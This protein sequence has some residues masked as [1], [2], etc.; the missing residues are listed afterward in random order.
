MFILRNE[1]RGFMKDHNAY[2]I[3]ADHKRLNHVH[4]RL[5]ELYR[6]RPMSGVH[7]FTPDPELLQGLQ[8]KL[9]I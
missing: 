2:R 1:L 6:D 8:E 4:G 7:G 5:N 9:I 3:R